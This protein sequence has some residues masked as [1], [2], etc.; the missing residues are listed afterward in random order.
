MV[1]HIDTWVTGGKV[2]TLHGEW[3]VVWRYSKALDR[4]IVTLVGIEEYDQLAI[5]AALDLVC[6]QMLVLGFIAPPQ[7]FMFSYELNDPREASPID[8]RSGGIE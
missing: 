5:V 6:R 8:P 3:T 2:H 7:S 4:M 1:S